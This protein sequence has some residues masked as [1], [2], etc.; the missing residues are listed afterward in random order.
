[1]KRCVS[2]MLIACHDRSGRALRGYC[3]VKGHHRKC[4][5]AATGSVRL[6]RNDSSFVLTGP[7]VRQTKFCSATSSRDGCGSMVDSRTSGL[8]HTGQIS[9]IWN[10][11][12]TLISLLRRHPADWIY[13]LTRTQQNRQNS[14]SREFQMRAGTLGILKDD[15]AIEVATGAT[16]LSLDL[17]QM[18]VDGAHEDFRVIA[19]DVG[20]LHREAARTAKKQSALLRRRS[21]CSNASHAG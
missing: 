14:A 3:I 2:W 5:H 10:C 12:A 11:N 16:F 6:G 19:D 17:A 18:L 4:V 13:L 1:M 15:R 7:Q 8:W 21:G 20:R 9:W